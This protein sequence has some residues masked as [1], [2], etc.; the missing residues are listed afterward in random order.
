MSNTPPICRLPPQDT[1]KRRHRIFDGKNS[2]RS[3]SPNNQI[4]SPAIK[5]P[6]Q[7]QSLARPVTEPSQETKAIFHSK[8][9]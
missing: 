2:N 4:L 6:Y 9:A 7:T 8:H 3:V 1:S 5:A